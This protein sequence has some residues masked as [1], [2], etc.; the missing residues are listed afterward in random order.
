MKKSKI[1]LTLFLLITLIATISSAAYNDVTMTVVEE[2]TATINFGTKSTVERSVISKDLKNKEITL[3]LKLNG[4]KIE[5]MA[6][7]GHGCA[8]S[9]ASTSIMI[10]TLKGKTVEEA[11]EIIKTFIEMIKRETTDEEEL[12]KLEDAI[13]FKNVSNMPARVKCALLAWHTI[14]DM[15]N[16][17]DSTGTGNINCSH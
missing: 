17:N 9:Q 4:N 14:E 13:A 6:F 10:D 8:I 11:K 16:K 1:L 5:D 15:L 7:S 12:K 2:P 3:Q